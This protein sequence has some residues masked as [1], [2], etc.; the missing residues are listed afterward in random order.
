MKNKLLNS[1]ILALLLSANFLVN[2]ASASI[3]TEDFS[4]NTYDTNLFETIYGSGVV[5]NES[6]ASSGINQR[7]MLRTK[8]N[9]FNPSA[10]SILE[11]S[12]DLT[13]SAWDIAFISWRSDG[14]HNPDVH[15]EPL[16]GLTLRLHED[17]NIDVAQGYNFNNVFWDVDSPNGF[18]KN[19]ETV[20]INVI[21]DGLNVDLSFLNLTTNATHAYSFTSNYNAGGYVA[22]TT[23]QGNSNWDN[24]SIKYAEPQ[25]G[26]GQITDVPEPSTL[27]IFALGMI[28]LASR[29]FKKQSL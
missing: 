22:F 18:F 19:H 10:S 14:T 25:G 5:S 21:D 9:T 12:A 6:W 27:A 16:S 24:I 4:S 15:N 3:I 1:S 26:A 28:G 11:I 8:E 2:V 7:D 29:R 17:D 23:T 13:F 20:R